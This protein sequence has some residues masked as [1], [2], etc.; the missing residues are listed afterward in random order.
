MARAATKRK[1][2][3]GPLEVSKDEAHNGVQTRS[4]N[5]DVHPAVAT[6]IAGNSR[7]PKGQGKK[8]LAKTARKSTRIMAEE[9]WA[10]TTKVLARLEQQATAAYAE[11]DTPRASPPRRAK[12]KAKV[13]PPAS[14]SPCSES[15]L[16]SDGFIPDAI[17]TSTDEDVNEDRLLSDEISDSVETERTKKKS[18]KAKAKLSYRSAINNINH[19][20]EIGIA[21]DVNGE[22]LDPATP[23]PIARLKTK[24][25]EVL[26]SFL[27]LKEREETDIL[28]NRVPRCLHLREEGAHSG[29]PLQ[30][31]FQIRRLLHNRNVKR[32]S[33]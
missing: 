23:R 29:Q 10:S 18:N 1:A 14:P 9:Q 13:A 8:E 25:N 21:M 32:S 28:T 7:A 22:E 11:T 17:Q 5:K 12:R 31:L 19:K 16:S 30:C 15:A 27:C 4:G 6:G 3:G 26:V 20:P 24:R 2:S 33:W